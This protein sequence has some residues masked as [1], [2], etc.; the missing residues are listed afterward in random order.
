MFRCPPVI[1]PLLLTFL[2]RWYRARFGLT[3]S[4]TRICFFAAFR[5]AILLLRRFSSA[6][7]SFRRFFR[8]AAIAETS[9]GSFNTCLVSKPRSEHTA[10]RQERILDAGTNGSTSI[11]SPNITIAPSYFFLKAGDAYMP[12]LRCARVC[13]RHAHVVCVRRTCC[14]RVWVGAQHAI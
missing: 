9:F 6:A 5:R 12:C 13:M 14:V 3:V 2:D 1:V 10:S 8:S 4:P 7:L 11:A